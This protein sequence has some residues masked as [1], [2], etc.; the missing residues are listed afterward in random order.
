MPPPCT[1]LNQQ[2]ISLGWLKRLVK[3]NLLHNRINQS[4]NPS[5]I[6]SG[7]IKTPKDRQASTAL[8]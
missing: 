7:G 4:A 2:S 6:L 8:A 3:A 1:T 5:P